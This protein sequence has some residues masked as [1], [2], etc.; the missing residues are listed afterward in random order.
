[1]IRVLHIVTYMG[2]GGLE[3]MLMNYYRNIDRSKIQFD[4]LTH[5][6]CEA[7]YDKEITNLGGK[8][9]HLP[10]LNP[11]S[12]SYLNAL[13]NFFANHKEYKIVHSHLDCMS[14][15]PLKYAKKNGVKVAIAHS[16][17]SNQPKDKKYLLKILYKRLI[18]KYADKL[19]A[20]SLNSG[21]WMFGKKY[22]NDITILN[23]AI[24]TEDYVY[25]YKTRLRVRERF[26]LDND[27]VIGHIGRFSIQKNHTFLLDIFKSVH[28]K[29]PC[30]KL[31][32]VG[33][34]ELRPSIERKIRDL[35]LCD[36]VILT[37]VVDNV[38]EISQAFDVFCFPSLFE[39]LSVAMIEMQAT[40]VKCIISDTI[41]KECIVTD[42][43]DVVSLK[44]DTSAWAE[45]IL[46][47]KDGYVHANMFDEISN[48][49][50]D[51]RNNSKW[52]QEFYLNE[53][54]K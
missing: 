5:R 17:N 20:C 1:M 19:F 28:D 23:N 51:I 25:N 4:F 9:Y 22:K 35:N 44:N 8:I 53:Y 29:F 47:Y 36:S 2:R 46:K 21:I 32:L 54:Y 52:L 16:H 14:S 7:D 40:G 49:N 42:N 43:V 48:K 39:G 34:G 12:K 26:G 10:Y 11:F 18:P 31:L 37:G 50:F 13:D 30:T 15:I 6:D 41:S 33:D 27:F 24:N 3:T 38:S 45:T